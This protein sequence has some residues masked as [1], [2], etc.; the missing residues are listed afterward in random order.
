MTVRHRNTIPISHKRTLPE[1]LL[2]RHIKSTLTL[3][4]L[5]S[6]WM[7]P[8]AS[9]AQWHSAAG[10][11]FEHGQLLDGRPF[12]WAARTGNP[13]L[14]RISHHA[15]ELQMALLFGD[16]SGA[17]RRFVDPGRHASYMA[18][19]SGSKTVGER[20]LF[21]GS[22]G[23]RRTEHHDW[24]WL[25][26]RYYEEAHPFLKADSTT[27]LSRYNEIV[28]TGGY[29]VELMPDWNLGASIYYLVDEGLKDVAPKPLSTHRDF[30]IR[31]G[32]S[33]RIGQM[34]LGAFGGLD[35]RE[36]E[37][38]YTEYEGAILEETI[39]INFR[40]Y[41]LPVVQ[42][43]DRETRITRS[44]EWHYGAHGSWILPE[45]L[46]LH[47]QYRGS[48]SA[49]DIEED[50]TR[51]RKEGYTS[52]N[53]HFVDADMI[54]NRGGN[55]LAAGYRFVSAE[56]WAE[57]QPFDVLLTDAQRRMHRF[58]TGW[59]SRVAGD[60]EVGLEWHIAY[61]DQSEDD[62]YS[63]VS[64]SVDHSDIGFRTGFAGGMGTRM[65]LAAHYGYLNRSASNSILETGSTG[66][67]FNEYRRRDIDFMLSGYSLH[68]GTIRAEIRHTGNHELH[69]GILARQQQGHDTGQKRRTITSSVTYRIPL[70]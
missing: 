25:S 43:R 14:L 18:R 54:W 31:L 3:V 59:S 8:A 62:Y 66:R 22:F 50:I 56:R 19:A 17:F 16:Q 65:R 40:G 7:V 57:F 69:I 49:L 58:V 24:Q 39:L 68:E 1:M 53:S 45:G 9:P 41:D 63:S 21:L 55:L 70:P 23:F 47:A 12:D 61:G 27:G 29:A 10:G 67:F 15:D 51:P 48:R 52:S 37:L 30:R 38:R 33:Y 35:D 4:A 44:T 5:L 2:T 46:R 11:P 26:T 28:V 60:L 34:E 32:T 36:E 6:V 64:W 20:Q 13:A 42:R